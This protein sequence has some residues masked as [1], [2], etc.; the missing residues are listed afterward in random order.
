MRAT[1]GLV[2]VE[3][4]LSLAL[5]LAEGLEGELLIVMVT[6]GACATE[7]SAALEGPEAE[8][9]KRTSRNR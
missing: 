3:F 8:S 7:V 4:V 5:A 1:L 6:G 2:C 9:A